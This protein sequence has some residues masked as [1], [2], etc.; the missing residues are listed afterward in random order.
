MGNR[1]NMLIPTV[2]GDGC[3]GAI[4]GT[5]IEGTAVGFVTANVLA[6]ATA[7]SIVGM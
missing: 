2:G 4:N 1:M 5:P 7:S 6:N 3:A